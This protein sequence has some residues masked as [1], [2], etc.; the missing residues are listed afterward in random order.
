V[1]GEVR[2]RGA[3]VDH[4]GAESVMHLMQPGHIRGSAAEPVAVVW[5]RGAV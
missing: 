4:V 5:A 3:V 2:G 1:E